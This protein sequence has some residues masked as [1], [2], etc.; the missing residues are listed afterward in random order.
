MGVSTTRALSLVASHTC[1]VQRPWYSDAAKSQQTDQGG[2]DE[3]AAARRAKSVGR[4]LS[5]RRD[6]DIMHS[7]RCAIACRSATSFLRVGHL[8]LFGHRCA[9][10]LPGNGLSPEELKCQLSALVKY[11]IEI[12]YAEVVEETNG[13]VEDGGT[14]SENAIMALAR[15]FSQRLARLTAN[16]RESAEFTW[17]GEDSSHGHTRVRR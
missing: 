1:E 4:H 8:E 16:W 7:E 6:P 9:G 10:R 12:E 17:A 11:A 3:A 2:D 13:K 15:A 5:G 14:V